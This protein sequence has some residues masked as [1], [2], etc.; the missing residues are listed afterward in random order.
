MTQIKRTYI[1]F[2]WK[3]ETGVGWTRE[4]ERESERKKRAGRSTE[5][6]VRFFLKLRTQSR[7]LLLIMKYSIVWSSVVCVFD[8]LLSLIPINPPPSRILIKLYCSPERRGFFF[9]VVSLS[10]LCAYNFWT[11][12]FFSHVYLPSPLSLSFTLV[13][14]IRAILRSCSFFMPF[15]LLAFLQLLFLY[16]NDFI[17]QLLPICSCKR[18]PITSP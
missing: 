1:R 4:R 5:E 18:Y 6:F 8:I 11:C 16:C 14:H 7:W 2:I 9:H 15:V 12:C 3:I 10:P 13:L 17:L